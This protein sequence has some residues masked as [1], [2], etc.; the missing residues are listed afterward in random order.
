MILLADSGST[1][2]EWI[3]LSGDRIVGSLF[4][5]GINPFYQD[6]ESIAQILINEYLSVNKDFDA[7]YFYGAGCIN[8]EK[9]DVVRSALL[10][11]FSSDTI[12]VGSDLIAAARSLCQNKP[13]IA[14][15]LG[16]GSNSCYYDGNEILNHVS[17]LGFIL[18]DEGSGAV[19]GKK[20]ISDILKKQLPPPLIENFFGT[21]HT[22]AAEILENVYKR[23]FPNRYLAGYSRFLSENLQFPEIEN[24]VL[25]G[26]REFVLRNLLQYPEIHHT[27]I[28]FTGSIAY[29]FEVQLRKVIEEQN[30][31]LGNIEPAP[32]KGLISYHQRK[33]TN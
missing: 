23:P 15:I 29:F 18:G 7:I 6:K 9:Q 19:L 32:M 30:L 3:I 21:Y 28:H 31:K 27:P 20:L 26:F 1:K 13:G 16:T 22:T 10:Q 24:I 5:S 2:S 11:V 4:T 8:P 17:P 25:T 12:F 33:I 14:C